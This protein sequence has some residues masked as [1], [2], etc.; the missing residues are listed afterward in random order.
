MHFFYGHKK[1]Y[2]RYM[3]QLNTRPRL[4][5]HFNLSVV[6]EFAFR[7]LS[8]F[9]F[10]SLFCFF[11]NYTLL[12]KLYVYPSVIR[13]FVIHTVFRHSYFFQS[14]LH[15]FVNFPVFLHLSDFLQNVQLLWK[16]SSY[17]S[18]KSLLFVYLSFFCMFL[19]CPSTFGFFRQF[20]ISFVN[21]DAFTFF[22]N[23]SKFLLSVLSN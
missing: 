14:I 9:R 11:V 8:V 23:V 19:V 5:Q 15:F 18:V 13:Y 2:R 20:S 12:R 16:S 3:C 10:L 17:S 21:S 7:F 6:G 22:R 4:R 1:H